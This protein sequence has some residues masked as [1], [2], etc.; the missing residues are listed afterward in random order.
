M[1]RR[2]DFEIA[3]RRGRRAGR[4]LLAI[5]LAEDP[6]VLTTVPPGACRVGFVV[7][8]GVGGAVVRNRVRRRLRALMAA[9]AARLPVPSLTVVR[10]NPASASASSH[11]LAEDLDGALTRLLGPAGPAPVAAGRDADPEDTPGGYR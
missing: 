5:H 11:E 9:R 1:R 8:R 6:R 10:A 7:S 3:V 4:R 2:E